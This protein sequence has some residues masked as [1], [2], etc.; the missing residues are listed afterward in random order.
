MLLKIECT[1]EPNVFYKAESFH[2]A[3]KLLNG[4]D[5]LVGRGGPFIVNSTFAL[6]LYLK[7]MMSAT[8]FGNGHERHD[9][10]I[11]YDKVHSKSEFEGKGH[12]LSSLFEQLP[13]NIKTELELISRQENETFNLSIFFKKYKNHFIDWRYSYEGTGESYISHDILMVLNALNDW[14]KKNLK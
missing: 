12:D 11:Q 3:A 6:E 7:S 14:C 9:G 8:I 13:E 1:V 4:S 10:F 5:L 2:L